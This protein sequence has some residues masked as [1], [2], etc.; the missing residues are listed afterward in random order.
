MSIYK[1]C[2]VAALDELTRGREEA[3]SAWAR[4]LEDKLEEKGLT[5]PQQ[6]S[7]DEL[8]KIAQ[9]LMEDLGIKRA[10]SQ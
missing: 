8:N 10:I 6:A 9:N 4:G 1:D 5:L 3:E 2:M 7:F